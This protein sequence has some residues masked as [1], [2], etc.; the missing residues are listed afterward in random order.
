MCIPGVRFA[1]VHD[2]NY[3]ENEWRVKAFLVRRT[4]IK[5]FNKNN[6]LGSALAII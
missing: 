5:L 3:R 1:A 4:I 6:W 2:P